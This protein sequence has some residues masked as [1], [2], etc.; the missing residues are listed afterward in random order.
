MLCVDGKLNLCQIAL[1]LSIG[2]LVMVTHAAVRLT[3]LDPH[4]TVIM[5]SNIVPAFNRSIFQYLH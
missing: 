5:G 3:V 4:Q 2:L 1:V